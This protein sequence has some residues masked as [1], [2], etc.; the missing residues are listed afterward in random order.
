MNIKEQWVNEFVEKLME[1]DEAFEQDKC[2]AY[3]LAVAYF[4]WGDN[5]QPEHTV[6]ESFQ[7]FLRYQAYG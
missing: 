4:D 6:D 7:R 2:Y 1:Y 5:D 3:Q